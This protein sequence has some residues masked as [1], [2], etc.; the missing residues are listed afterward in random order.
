MNLGVFL[1]SNGDLVLGEVTDSSLRSIEGDINADPVRD[2]Y[3]LHQ[4]VIMKHIGASFPTRGP[5]EGMQNLT[6]AVL[7]IFVHIGVDVMTVTGYVGV[8]IVSG[9][10]ESLYLD[11][12]AA[13]SK[14]IEQR[15][16]NRV[17]R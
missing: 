7:P 4:P 16:N 17:V 11:Y 9:G 3:E 5:V 10:S 8:S 2:S 15:K 1:M 14:L 13:V 12:K 6:G